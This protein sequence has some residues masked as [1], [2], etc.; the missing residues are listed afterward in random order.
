MNQVPGT[1]VNPFTFV[2]PNRGELRRGV[3]TFHD[4]RSRD[5][6]AGVLEVSWRLAS[7]LLLPSTAEEE[8]WLKDDQITVPGSSVAGS[9]RSLHEALFNGCYRVVDLDFVPS[10]RESAKTDAELQLAVVSHAPNGVPTELRLC[11]DTVWVDALDLLRRWPQ[12]RR[13][14]T[15]GDVIDINGRVV[16]TSLGRAEFAFISKVDVV[17]GSDRHPAPNADSTGHRVLLI[18][19]T[20]ARKRYKRDRTAARALWATGEITDQ[21]VQI[22]KDKDKEML[23]NWN[24]ACGS[25][26][27]RRRL[28]QAG[29]A[30]DAGP[31]TNWRDVSQ[32]ENV[33]W[34][35]PRGERDTTVAR[36]AKASGYL[37][38]GDVVWV[39]LAGGRV[40][41]MKLA[42]IWRQAGAT[43]VGERLPDHL[44]PCVP[45]GPEPHLCLSCATFGA[46]DTEGGKR[47]H[48]ENYS[49]H[50][51]FG[52]ARSEG[53]ITPETI[54]L[55]PLGQPRAG[56]G[57]FYLSWG[58]ESLRIRAK[59]DVAAHWG[60]EADTPPHNIAGRK[61]Y[62]HSD[63]DT[64]AAE[65][66]RKL[67]RKVGPRYLPTQ[68][69]TRGKM[70][71]LAKL[72]P[73]GTILTSSI[74]FDQLDAIAVHALLAAICPSRVLSRLPGSA[75]A[76]FATHLGGG[77]PFG[78]GSVVP[79]IVSARITRQVDRYRN[80]DAD[81]RD[82]IA[83]EFPF[84]AVSSR[85]G[86]FLPGLA[87]LVKVLDIHGLGDSEP[88]VTYPPGASWDD[89]QHP[90]PKRADAF[91]QSYVWF[92]DADGLQLANTAKPW[93]PLPPADVD[94]TL[95]SKPTGPGRRR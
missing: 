22:D 29:N 71:R 23:A 25:S 68:Q 32:Y 77:K 59:G 11:H 56:N 43:S 89:Y 65:L 75:G 36:R 5:T 4:G 55:A 88:L 12:A 18:T 62:W 70:A 92:G 95:P 24:A 57:M 53:P 19:S 2:R 66:S 84:G 83:E 63:P 46:A 7:P 78:F 64:Q 79:T 81:P 42:Q 80:P 35:G 17:H 85:V 74:S 51:R 1:F 14:P 39:R 86:R 60:S 50:V 73:A 37:F 31:Q 21:T 16:D 40:A 8:G 38:E 45:S 3:P 10:Y 41:E 67:G 27:D 54:D 48:N 33:P 26:D 34:W 72:V 44:H 20:S 30:G 13:K 76:T 47:D 52:A 6:Y 90:D 91:G 28:E 61:F 93:F 69:Q 87:S 82:W 49:G 58:A 15:S 94:P 9:V